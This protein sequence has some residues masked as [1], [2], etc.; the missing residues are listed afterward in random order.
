ML[1]QKFSKGD[2]VIIPQKVTAYDVSI[3][4]S[5]SYSDIKTFDRP[6]IGFFMESVKENPEYSTV[7]IDTKIWYVRTGDISK[8]E[9]YVGKIDRSV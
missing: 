5:W 7:I 4:E 1:V 3:G 2:I 6:T 8:G 9:N